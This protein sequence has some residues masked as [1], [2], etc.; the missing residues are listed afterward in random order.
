MKLN[1]TAINWLKENSA[2]YE[3]FTWASKECTTLAEVVATARPDWAIWVYTRPGVLDDRTLWLF[4]CWCAEQSLVN[5]YKVYPED[6]RPK[7]A[8]EARRGWLEGTVTDQELLAARSAAESAAES[9]WSAARSAAW[10][11]AR[12]AAESAQANWLR[13]NATTPNFVDKV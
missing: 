10:S 7:Q 8:I 11:A 4:A 2:C 1:Q 12:S 6:H 13:E 3:G 9:A 5:W